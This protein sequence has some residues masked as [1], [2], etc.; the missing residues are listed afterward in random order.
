MAPSGSLVLFAEA[1]AGAGTTERIG[2]RIARVRFVPVVLPDDIRRAMVAHSRF[3]FP[4]EGCG[5]LAADDEGRIRMAYCLS[6][7]ERSAVTFAL[8]P[9]EHYRALEH[10][11]RN[12]WSLGGVFHSHTRSPAYPSDTD[13]ARALDPD[14]LYVL[15]GLPDADEPEV[16][17][18]WIRNGMVSEEPLVLEESRV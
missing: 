13:V 12:G 17:G 15:V 14:W 7:A 11:E 1:A 3:S 18:F 16:R 5:L 4:E 9:D 8:D 10:A 6:N 2:R